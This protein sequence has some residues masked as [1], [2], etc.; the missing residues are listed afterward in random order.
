MGDIYY[1]ISEH[2]TV[3]I[4]DGEQIFSD[5]KLTV[6]VLKSEYENKR[7]REHFSM[8]FRDKQIKQILDNLV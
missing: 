2:D 8:Y 6:E 3:R 7:K 4:I 5:K 1:K